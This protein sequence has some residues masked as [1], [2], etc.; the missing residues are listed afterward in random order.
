MLYH[1]FNIFTEVWRTKK[2]WD[3]EICRLY[4]L[5]GCV[6]GHQ[7]YYNSDCKALFHEDIMPTDR[8]SRKLRFLS[9]FHLVK[10]VWI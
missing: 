9:V 3:Q 10:T 1:M 6:L 2:R 7:C 5:R 8:M 4:P